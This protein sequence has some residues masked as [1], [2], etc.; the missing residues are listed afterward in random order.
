ML[1]SIRDSSELKV[2]KQLKR[3]KHKK[4]VLTETV[5]V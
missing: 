4:F 5:G 2:E 1:F 3:Q